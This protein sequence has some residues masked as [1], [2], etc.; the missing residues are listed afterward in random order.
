MY[1]FAIIG[2]G[3]AGAS[4]GAELS[5]QGSVVLL[6]AEEQPGYHATGRSAALFVESYGNALIRGLATGSKAFLTMP[7]EGFVADPLLTPRGCL[8]I[9]RQDQQ[10]ELADLCSLASERVDNVS[11]QDADFA[12]Q[13]V[14]ALRPEYVAG[15]VWEPD[16]QEIDVH[17][18]LQGYLRRIRANDGKVLCN[19]RV[20]AIEQ[21]GEGWRL[22]AGDEQVEARRIINAAGAWADEIAEMAGAARVGLTPLRRSVCIVPPPAGHDIDHWPMVI[23]ASEEFYFKP[24]A[25]KIMVSPGDQT[26][27]PPMDAFADDMDLAVA[28]DRMQRSLEIEVTRIEHSW[29]GLRTFAP[30]HTPVV[31]YDPEV[32]NFFWLAGQGG[33]GIMSA[34]ALSRTA[35]SLVTGGGVP[36]DLA[37]LGVSEAA[38]SPARRFE[39]P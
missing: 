17:G 36:D 14:P 37:E 20:A 23:D 26:P 34:P 1:D 25:G 24:D 4:V 6:E 10:G 35:A 38:L 7:P 11:L 22:Q 29:A 32:G 2:A 39:S 18:L 12:L 8:Y 21:S 30:D 5:A 27:S 3:I 28:I 31:G 16:G 15:C 19:K 9:G 13:K 33:Y